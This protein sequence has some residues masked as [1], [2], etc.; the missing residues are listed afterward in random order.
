M[1]S[2]VCPGQGSQ[3]P[4]FLTPWLEYEGVKQHLER[5]SEAAELDLGYYGTQADEQTIKDT[6]IAQPLIVAA[7]LIAGRLLQK[8]PAY[9]PAEIIFAGHSVGEVTAAALS[10]V[11]SDQDALRFIKVRA[12]GMAAAAQDKASGMCAVLGGEQNEVLAAIQEAGLTAA[13]FNGP[14]QIVAAG[15]MDKLQEFAAQPPRKTRVISLKV[16]AA[17]HTPFMEAA[18][19]PL[20]SFA[21]GLKVE[22]PN[23]LLLANSDGKAVQSGRDFVDG[24]VNQVVKPVRWDLCMQTLAQSQLSTL[25]EVCPA[26]TLIGL[27]KRSL[28]G[29]PTIAVNTPADLPAASQALAA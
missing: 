2:I 6:V 19:Q 29:L 16:A 7:G 11:L 17:F 23:S 8:S 24:L 10:G 15:S 28:K 1:I 18:R 4:G 3:K 26:A 12:Q 20:A 25:L 13:N 27:A 14:G 22:D 21:A 9:Q 5:L